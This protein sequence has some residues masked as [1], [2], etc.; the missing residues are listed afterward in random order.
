[1]QILSSCGVK[2]DHEMTLSTNQTDMNPFP[3]KQRTGRERKDEEGNFQKPLISLD[4]RI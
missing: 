1:V 2:G 4:F 3:Q